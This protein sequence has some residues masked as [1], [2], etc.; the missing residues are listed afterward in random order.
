MPLAIGCV[1]LG[2]VDPVPTPTRTLAE[3]VRWDK[4]GFHCLE[5]IGFSRTKHHKELLES[6]KGAVWGKPP[7]D[8]GLP[9]STWPEESSLFGKDA[10]GQYRIVTKFRAYMNIGGLPYKRLFSVWGT[11]DPVSCELTSMGEIIGPLD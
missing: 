2:L 4:F 8:H 1:T 5:D 9:F 10:D 7:F 3:Q 11:F 6:V